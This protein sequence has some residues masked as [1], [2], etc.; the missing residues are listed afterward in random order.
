M[1]IVQ[2]IQE[3]CPNVGAPL[4]LSSGGGG[5]GSC[6]G[7]CGCGGGGGGCGCG[8]GGGG[9]SGGCGGQQRIQVSS[10][11]LR[12]SYCDGS[13]GAGSCPSSSGAVFSPGSGPAQLSLPPALHVPEG[14]AANSVTLLS[15]WGDSGGQGQINLQWGNLFVSVV[16]AK[17]GPW[18]PQPTL[19]FNSPV[20]GSSGFGL[21]WNLNWLSS[22]VPQSTTSANVVDSAGVPL[23]ETPV[24]L[25]A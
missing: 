12:S 7:G 17:A 24:A 20:S 4:Y 16:P 13:G 19:L 15:G 3:P 9:C 5:G 2:C 25:A 8:G 14:A 10:F 11:G 6:G 1:V 21:G 22:V 23:P 18:D